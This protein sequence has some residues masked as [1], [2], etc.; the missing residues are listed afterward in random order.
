MEKERLQAWDD[1]RKLTS[2]MGRMAEE[3][4]WEQVGE[5]ESRRRERLERFFSTPV[6]S[7]DAPAV[8][9]AIRELM[10]LDEAITHRGAALREEVARE[11]N[12]ISKGRR[13]SAAYSENR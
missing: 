12:T 5:L 4:Q 11:L 13:A 9:E 8:A 10:A 7:S 3:G 1:I 2:A 6:P